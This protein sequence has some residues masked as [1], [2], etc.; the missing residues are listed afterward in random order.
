MELFHNRSCCVGVF[1]KSPMASTLRKRTSLLTSGQRL[2]GGSVLGHAVLLIPV[3]FGWCGRLPV[4]F[5]SR[6][7]AIPQTQTASAIIERTGRD[8]LL[9]EFVSFVRAGVLD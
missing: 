4:S 2:E 3:A 6:V 1:T 5:C 8:D 9:A 7:L